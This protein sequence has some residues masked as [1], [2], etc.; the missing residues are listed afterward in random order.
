V[1]HKAVGLALFN[2]DEDESMHIR[3][4]ES[5]EMWLGT[6]Q[7]AMQYIAMRYI[8]FTTVI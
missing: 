6:R 2:E 7:T 4:S 5:K 8:I 3:L 1:L